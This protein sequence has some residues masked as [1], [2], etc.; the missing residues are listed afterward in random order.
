M[1]IIGGKYKNR[2]FYMPKDCRT[3]QNVVRKALFDFLGQDMEGLD[4]LDLYAGSGAVGLEAISRGARKV[5]FVEKE[6]KCS[7]VIESNLRLFGIDPYEG[8]QGSAEIFNS[9]AF[10]SI[11]QFARFGRKFHVVFL[12]P[13]YGVE[14]A[15]KTLKT[16]EGY[17]ILH[18]N[19]VLVIQHEKREFLPQQTGRYSLYKQRNYGSTFLS[20]YKVEST[21]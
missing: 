4:F 2:N 8:S 20:V 18:P 6:F 19:S 15:K 16:L 17:D 1:K 12:D 21:S 10:V 7:Q 5:S 11:K 9:D 13:P 3:T 14:L